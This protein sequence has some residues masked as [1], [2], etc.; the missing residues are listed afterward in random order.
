MPKTRHWGP[1]L[2][3]KSR[4]PFGPYLAGGAEVGRGAS[5]GFIQLSSQSGQFFSQKWVS[6]WFLFEPIL[7]EFPS[8]THIPLC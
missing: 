2:T 1:S 5:V 8:R 7:K 4:S 3:P 6:F